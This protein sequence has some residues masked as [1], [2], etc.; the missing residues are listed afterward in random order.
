MRYLQ[1]FVK[2]QYYFDGCFEL[3]LNRSFKSEL[4][5]FFGVNVIFFNFCK[6]KG[7]LIVF[8]IFFVYNDFL[9]LEV[10]WVRL[11]RL[12]YYICIFYYSLR[13]RFILIFIKWWNIKNERMQFFI[14]LGLVF[15]R[16]IFYFYSLWGGRKLQFSVFNKRIYILQCGGLIYVRF[17]KS[18]FIGM[19]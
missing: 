17:L 13:S 7:V 19:G 16:G 18:L 6:Q 15:V 12:Q 11:Y 14:V 1:S 3:Y 10:R 4:F 8:I 9:E 2:R 5:C